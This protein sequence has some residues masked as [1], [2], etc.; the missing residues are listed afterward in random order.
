MGRPKGISPAQRRTLARLSALAPLRGFYLAGGTAIAAHLG[1]RRSLDLDIFSQSAKA[2]L[3]RA[4]EAIVEAEGKAV[5][6]STTSATV[7]LRVDGAPVDLVCYPYAPLVKPKLGPGDFPL[8]SL[9]DLATMKLSAIARRGLRRDFWDLHAITT[10]G[11]ISLPAAARGYVKRFGV[12]E[13]DLYAVLR[14]LTYFVDA[15]ADVLWP[16]GLSRQRWAK[17]RRY[18]EENAPRLL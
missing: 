16:A 1:H 2:S 5:V 17:I 15:D 4:R 10:D 18:F 6:V 9:L 12:K 13:S 7:R 11:G 14:A 8:A 3:D